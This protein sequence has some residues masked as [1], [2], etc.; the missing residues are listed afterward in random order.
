[1]SDIKTTL[2]LHMPQW[3]G[4]NNHAYHFGAELLAWIAPKTNDPI[5]NVPVAFEEG[6]VLDNEN[7][8]FGRSEILSQTQKACELI[9]KHMPDKLVILGGDCLIDLAPFAYLSE[10]YQDDLGILW[11]DAHPDIMTPEQY[12]H[13]HAMVLRALM[14]EGDEDLRRFAKYPI[15]ANKIMYAGVNEE[16][17]YE[18]E[19]IQSNGMNVCR[20]EAIKDDSYLEMIKQWVEDENIKYLAIHL[21]LDVLSIDNFASLY[22]KNPHVPENAFEGI[23]QGKLN[24][25]EVLKVIG[26]ASELTEVVGLGIAE[27]MPWD[28]LNLKKMLEKLPLLGN[29]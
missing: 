14:G 1:M 15:K 18:A 19:F 7:G 21:D 8:I 16:S 2:R 5:E 20:P 26:Q 27:H 23:A 22:F 6:K 4:G 11:V 24:M 10:K 13:G 12:Y 28:T 9:E 3:Q 17:E 25:Q 29:S